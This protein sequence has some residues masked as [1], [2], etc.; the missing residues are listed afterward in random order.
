MFKEHFHFSKNSWLPK[1]D[2]NVGQL[3]H[4]DPLWAS[5]LYTVSRRIRLLYMQNTG[6]RFNCA[7]NRPTA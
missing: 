1:V 2:P 4:L 3:W 5:M 6:N 7:G